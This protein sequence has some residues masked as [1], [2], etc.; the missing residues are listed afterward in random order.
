MIFRKILK[1][2]K[3]FFELIKLNILQNIPKKFDS[4]YKSVSQ[5]TYY[6][7]YALKASLNP[8]IFKTFRRHPE[9]T[10]I[11]EHVPQNIAQEYLKII[12]HKFS[13][14]HKYMKSPN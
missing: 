13:I 7:E 2:Y 4:N 8:K 9:Y 10:S 14:N 12:N 11:L 6:P 5:S 3:K 1:K